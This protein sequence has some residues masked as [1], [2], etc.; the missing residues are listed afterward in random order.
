MGVDSVRGSS[1]GSSQS[2]VNSYN[3]TQSAEPSPSSSGNKVAE[4]TTP[5]SASTKPVVNF[6]QSRFDGA[7]AVSS[8][9]ALLQSTP[10][11]RM[12]FNQSSFDAAKAFSSMPELLQPTPLNP[13]PQTFQPTAT[14]P[15][16]VPQGQLTFNAEGLEDR[17]RYFSREAHWPGGASGVTIGRGYDMKE[18]TTDEVLADLTAAGVPQA[19][20]E[21]LAQGA[22]LEDDEA[23]EFVRGLDGLEITPE[24]QQAL[25]ST[26][27]EEYV[28]DVRRISNGPSQVEAYGNV[29]W[30]NLD[31]AIQDAIVDLRYRGDY[32]P[33]TRR[34]VQPLVVANDLQGLHDLL[35]DEN[36]MINDWGVPRDRFERRRDYLADALAERATTPAPTP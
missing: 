10:V 17:G 33:L 19:D 28:T 26:V 34:D 16:T 12:N 23:A 5:S 7:K 36:R 14:D 4:A 30:E 21:R 31:P 27:Y 25:F 22:G 35:A 11:D 8:T 9:P 32:T 18:R 29:D 6:D 3:K 24:A 15:F 2:S 13:T 1:S 20:A